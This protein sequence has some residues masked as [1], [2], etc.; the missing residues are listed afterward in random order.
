MEYEIASLRYLDALNSQKLLLTPS[1][2]IVDNTLGY[3]KIGALEDV[4]I[5]VNNNVRKA[6]VGV[7]SKGEKVVLSLEKEINLSDLLELQS[8]QTGTKFQIE[9]ANNGYLD[10][11]SIW[12]N[13]QY[14]EIWVSLSPNSISVKYRSSKLQ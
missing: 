11:G 8:L 13:S 7:Y 1:T 9:E 5:T 4:Y 6:N 12:S 3:K 10:C 2:I 14:A